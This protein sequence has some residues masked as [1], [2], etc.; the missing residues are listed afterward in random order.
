MVETRATSLLETLLSGACRW[1]PGNSGKSQWRVRNLTLLVSSPGSLLW[2]ASW[3]RETEFQA[4]TSFTN[5]D[6]YKFSFRAPTGWWQLS[7][8]ALSFLSVLFCILRTWLGFLPAWDVPVVGSCT[9]RQI[10]HQFWGPKNMARQKCGLHSFFREGPTNCCQLSGE[11]SF[12]FFWL[13]LGDG[14]EPWEYSLLLYLL[15]G[16]LFVQKAIQYF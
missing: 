3:E 13:S 15:W 12:P 7:G 9:H 8:T 14:S 11:L 5:L 4:V 10:N 1:D 2:V 16:C 6:S